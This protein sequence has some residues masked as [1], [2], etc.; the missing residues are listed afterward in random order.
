MEQKF[1]T[2]KSDFK[3]LIC[4]CVRER[5]RETEIRPKIIVTIIIIVIIIIGLFRA[6][7]TA[8]GGSQARGRIGAAV[9]GLHHSHSNT[10][11]QPCLRP[12]PQL[13]SMPDL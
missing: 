3:A 1:K 11:S 13:T 5:D 8:Y 2:R 6:T 4:V 10:E 7:P 9:A 12:T